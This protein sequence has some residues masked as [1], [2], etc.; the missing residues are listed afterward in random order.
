MM[1]GSAKTSDIG[2]M[3]LWEIAVSYGK[4]VASEAGELPDGLVDE[5]DGAEDPEAVEVVD[6]D[7][8]ELLGL[9]ADD[10]RDAQ[11]ELKLTVTPCPLAEVPDWRL[12]VPKPDQC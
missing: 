11:V 12:P 2:P 3:T 9:E 5:G 7:D 4:K 1:A 10:R 8:A 6:V